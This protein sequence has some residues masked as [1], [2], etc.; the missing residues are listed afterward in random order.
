MTTDQI[1]QAFVLSYVAAILGTMVWRARRHP[2]GWQAWFLYFIAA[3]YCRICFHWRSDRPCPF[4]NAHPALLV[5]NHRSPLDP[6]FIWVG[7]NSYRPLE[8]M[9]AREYFGIPGLQFIFDTMRAIPVA[10]DGKDM[11]AT[12]TALRRLHE[13]RL[14]GVFP[15]GRINTNQG[16]ELLP[17]NTGVAWLALHSKAPVYP[18]F[19]HNAPRGKG[20]IDPFYRF[21]RVRVTYGDAMDISEYYGRKTTPAL[22]QEVTDIMMLRLA[23]LGGVEYPRADAAAESSPSVLRITAVG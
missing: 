14:V 18:I 1:A 16:G 10:R 3:T 8:F 2:E 22:L 21:T 20:M 12:R 11:G 17:G 23:E 13:G 7:V 4:S 9:T 6:M 19:I 15:E 5:A